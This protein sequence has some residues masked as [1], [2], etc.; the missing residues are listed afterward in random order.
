MWKP[1][2]A[3]TTLIIAGT[4]FAHAQDTKPAPKKVWP[5]FEQAARQPAL[6]RI[7]QMSTGIYGVATSRLVDPVEWQHRRAVNFNEAAPK[8]RS[9]DHAPLFKSVDEDL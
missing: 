9:G 6:V 2:V 7:E 5:S 3:G 4:A 8:K 1:V